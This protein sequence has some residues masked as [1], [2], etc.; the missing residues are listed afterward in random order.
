VTVYRSTTD[1]AV[2]SGADV[3]DGGDVVAGFRCMSRDIFASLG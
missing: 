2:K 3:L 1:I